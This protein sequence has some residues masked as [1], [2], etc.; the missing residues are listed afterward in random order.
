MDGSERLLSGR[1]WRNKSW[2]KKGVNPKIVVPQN[3]WFIMENPIK[4]DDLGV[5]LFL[6]TSIWVWKRCTGIVIANSWVNRSIYLGS[7]LNTVAGRFIEVQLQGKSEKESPSESQLI[8]LDRG[9]RWGLHPSVACWFEFP[10]N[11]V[12][13]SKALKL[14]YSLNL[15]K[16]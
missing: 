2:G 7:C 15:N 14:A 10:K 8:I 3:A 11:D 16:N 12:A 6:E 13:S 5:P 1:L 4:M 9:K